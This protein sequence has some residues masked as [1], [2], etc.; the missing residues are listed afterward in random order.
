MSTHPL[1]EILHPRAI[2]VVGASDS[3]GRGSGFISPLIELGYKGQIYPVNPKYSEVMGLKAYPSVKDIPGVVDFVISSIPASGVLNMIDDCTQKGV[4]GI[5]LFTA[6]FS[7]TGRKEAAELE[8]EVLRRARRGGI[9]IIGPNCMGV[10]YPAEG[11]SFNNGMPRESGKLGL[12][13][14]S[15]QAVG[16][17]VG[18]AAQAGLRFSKGISYGNALDFN[19]CDYLEYLAQDPDTKIIL[20]YVEGVR[21]GKRFFDTLRRTTDTKPV[22]IVKGGRGQS[23]TRATA[24]HTASLAGSTEVW[25][26]AVSQAGAISAGDLEELVDIAT[27]L[28]FSPPIKGRRVGVAGGSGGSSVLAADQCEEAGLD[29]IALPVEIREELK[30][31]GDPTWDWLGNPADFS[32]TAD[33]FDMADMIQ[34]MAEHPSFDLLMLFLHTPWRRGGHH[35][36]VSIDE[37][38]KNY[39]LEVLK[40]KPLLVISQERLWGG[41]DLDEMRKLTAEMRSKVIAAG[42]SIYPSIAR[43]ARAAGKVIDFYQKRK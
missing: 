22:V 16:E 5:H 41:D 4:K 43:A 1:E 6:R 7:E 20:M 14:Q 18:L 3:G 11:I 33:N 38:L 34:M 25:K 10:Y 36:P 24:S 27:L 39:R 26:T 31:R 2:A 37:H 21:D 13:S 35:Q 17:I 32:I 19:E 29:V 23:G 28:Y 9:R 42:I 30:R 15:G 40:R 8:R 12:A